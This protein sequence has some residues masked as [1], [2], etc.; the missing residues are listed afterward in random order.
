MTKLKDFPI[1]E[2]ER[3]I[4][5]RLNVNDGKRILEIFSDEEIMKYYGKYPIH[6]LSEAL[7]LI[8]KLN[9]NFDEG[10]G[11]RWAI[12]LKNN[13]ELIGT[14]GLHSWN[15]VNARIEVG[16]EL[17]KNYW[18]NGFVREAVQEVTNYAFESLDIHRIEALTYPENISSIKSLEALGFAYEG[19][20]RGYAYFREMHQD[21]KMFSLLK[22]N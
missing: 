5:R 6:E 15:K 20:L 16:Y 21:L 8:D 3:L 2:T 17:H 10:R 4:L 9:S 14:C 22:N 18:G 12:E 7:S 1:I 11:I 13:Q 19:E